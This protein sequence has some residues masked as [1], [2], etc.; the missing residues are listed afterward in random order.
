MWS[1]SCQNSS[2][3]SF[4]KLPG[5]PLDVDLPDTWCFY[6]CIVWMWR[7]LYIWSTRLWQTLLGTVRGRWAFEERWVQR[8]GGYMSKLCASFSKNRWAHGNPASSAVGVL[9]QIWPISPPCAASIFTLFQ[10]DGGSFGTDKS[11]QSEQRLLVA[12]GSEQ[13]LIP[14]LLLLDAWEGCTV[15]VCILVGE[16]LPLSPFPRWSFLGRQVVCISWPPEWVLLCRDT[17]GLGKLLVGK[18]ST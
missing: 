10:S 6:L 3:S 16:T 1:R 8:R 17:R 4:Q 7:R 5:F 15:W 9:K 2:A 18:G 13:V 11:W 12:S 14:M